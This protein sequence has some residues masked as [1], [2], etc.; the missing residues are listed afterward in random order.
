M[1]LRQH[2]LQKKCDGALGQ[3][4]S[5]EKQEQHAELAQ[6]A[7]TQE[8]DRWKKFHVFEPR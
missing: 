5:P 4:L 7:K 8:L 2:E 1:E 3:E 6:V